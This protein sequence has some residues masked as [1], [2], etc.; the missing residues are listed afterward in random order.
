MESVR[1]WWQEIREDG[2]TTPGTDASCPPATQNPITWASFL[3]NRSHPR[4]TRPNASAHTLLHSSRGRRPETHTVVIPPCFLEQQSCG[5][6]FFR[7]SL[8][9]LTCLQ[10]LEEF[11]LTPVA[12]FSI[13]ILNIL[14]LSRHGYDWDVPSDC[15]FEYYKRKSKEQFPRHL[16]KLPLEDHTGKEKKKKEKKKPMNE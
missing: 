4:K 12:F 8:L 2:V 15:N 9:L 10:T 5:I 1:R 7:L 13:L 6:L 14:L 3:W 16:I 11:K